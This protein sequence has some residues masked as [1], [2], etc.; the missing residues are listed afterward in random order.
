MTGPSVVRRLL[1]ASPVIAPSMLRCD[2]AGLARELLLLESAD[3]RLLHWDVMDGHF[4]PNLSYGAM[5]IESLR[6]MTSLPFEAHLMISEPQRYLSTFLDAG[7]D[8]ITF[9]CEAVADPI[10][11]LREIRQSGAAAGLALNPNTP[12]EAIEPALGECDLVLVMSVEPGFGGQTFQPA[13]L[14]K[15]RRLREWMGPQGLLSIDGGIGPETITRA[16]SAGANMF[17]V[18][19]EIFDT[20]DYREAISGLRSAAAGATGLAPMI[21]E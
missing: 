5:V 14:E 13:V 2:F 18:G 11:L 20:T 4:V 1:D 7:C 15:V 17:V 19:S 3:A 16:A 21:S 6:E 8:L 9:H 10:P 12:V